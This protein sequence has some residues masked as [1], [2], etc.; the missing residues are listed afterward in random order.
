[1]L[2]PPSVSYAHTEEARRERVYQGLVDCGVVRHLVGRCVPGDVGV[3][4]EVDYNGLS[5]TGYVVL[6]DNTCP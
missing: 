2:S 5:R 3:T 1:M 4:G 6:G